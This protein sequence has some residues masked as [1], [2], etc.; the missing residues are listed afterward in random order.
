M[1]KKYEL[2][3]ETVEID[4]HVLHRIR[5]ARDFTRPNRIDIKAGYLGGFIEKEDNLSHDGGCWAFDDTKVYENAKVSQ[6]ASVCGN[7]VV[8]GWA[9]VQDKAFVSD[10]VLING[11]AWVCDMSWVTSRA[12]VGGNAMICDIARVRGDA[13]VTDNATISEYAHVWDNAV[14]GGNARIS[15]RA[16]IYD[17]AHIF[18]DT[19]TFNAVNI[20]GDA[21]IRSNNDLYFIDGPKDHPMTFFN[22]SKEDGKYEVSVGGGFNG[23]LAEFEAEVSRWPDK[24]GKESLAILQVV[25]IHFDITEEE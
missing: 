5:A 19:F 12:R 10:T 21:Y 7:A 14:V 24:L 2:T 1:E 16:N 3:D 20:C 23:T 6:D 17:N 15:G 9:K 13:T 4:G 8:C 25:K 22:T 18:G 11:N